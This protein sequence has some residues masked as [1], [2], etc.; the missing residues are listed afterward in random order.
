MADVLSLPP[1]SCTWALIFS[2]KNEENEAA[3]HTRAVLEASLR[4]WSWMR[5]K[6][7]EPLIESTALMVGS[8]P[9][10]ITTD[11]YLAR[12][13]GRSA[14]SFE[15]TN[16]IL[17]DLINALARGLGLRSFELYLNGFQV[18]LSL[19]PPP[20]QTTQPLSESVH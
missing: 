19:G 7:K 4:V 12:L 15:E 20:T 6:Q 16:Q 14:F 5:A 8:G 3:S 1:P 9:N 18:P 2:M 11:K 10:T 17:L 13:F